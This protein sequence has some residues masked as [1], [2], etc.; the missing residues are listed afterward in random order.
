MIGRPQAVGE[1]NAEKAALTA[2]YQKEVAEDLHT[3]KVRRRTGVTGDKNYDSLM[4][5]MVGGKQG[6]LTFE[7]SQLGV[8]AAAAGHQVLRGVRGKETGGQYGKTRVGQVGREG[9]PTTSPT[10]V[11]LSGDESSQKRDAKG[12]SVFMG[13]SGSTSD[14]VRS[15]HAAT[16]NVQKHLSPET[17]FGVKGVSKHNTD[18]ATRRLALKWM[19]TGAPAQ[20]VMAGI[21]KNLSTPEQQRISKGP[22][23]TTQTHTMSEIADAVTKTRKIL[24]PKSSK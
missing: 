9:H 11:D 13:T 1:V 21:E 8:Q 16:L 17:G 24:Q 19:R 6:P 23:D 15:H 12:V 18:V 14:V 20:N 10:G 4:D 7:Q 2:S 22:V 5:L 3:A